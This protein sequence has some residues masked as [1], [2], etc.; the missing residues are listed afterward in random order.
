MRAK[1]KFKTKKSMAAEQ[2]MKQSEVIPAP[3]VYLT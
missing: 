2:N 3:T 1:K